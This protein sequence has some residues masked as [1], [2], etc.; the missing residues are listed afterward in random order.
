MRAR[1]VLRDP[2]ILLCLGYIVVLL[3]WSVT[4]FLPHSPTVADPAVSLSAPGAGYWFGTDANGYDLLSRTVYA[5]KFDVLTACAA[6]LVAAVAGSW[7][8]IAMSTDGRLASLAS[9]GLDVFQA[10]PLLVIAVA[11]VGLVGASRPVLVLIIA[12][13]NVPLFI[14]LV[15]AEGRL[16]RRRG[17]VTVARVHG[18]PE[19]TIRWRHILPNVTGV[20]FPQLSLSTGYAAASVGALS[21]LGLSEPGSASWGSMIKDGVPLLALGQWWI[22]FFPSLALFLLVLSFSELSHRVQSLVETPGGHS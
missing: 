3:G 22:V 17:F 18:V 19:R 6:V 16:V 4:G 10:V 1:A 11:V 20:I 15:Q 13:I 8:G 21:F 14:R 9:R 5:A 2:V 7:A 12:A